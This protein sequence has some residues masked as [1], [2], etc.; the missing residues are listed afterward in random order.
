MKGRN[1]RDIERQQDY[2]GMTLNPCHGFYYI[3][4]KHPADITFNPRI[5]CLLR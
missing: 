4:A 3:R 1:R 2:L 5:K